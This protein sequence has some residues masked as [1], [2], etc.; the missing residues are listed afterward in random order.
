MRGRAQGHQPRLR[1]RRPRPVDGGPAIYI[2]FGNQL[3]VVT[4]VA[5]LYIAVNV[6]LTGIATF[7]QRR[8]VGEHNPIDLTRAG[9]MDG[10]QNAGGGAL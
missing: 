10:G 4:V 2:Q 6:A 7:L 8:Y 3:Q 9:T 1:H 5:A